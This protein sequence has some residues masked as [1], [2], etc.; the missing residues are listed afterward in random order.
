MAKLRDY[1]MNGTIILGVD[2]VTGI[3]RRRDAVLRLLW[4]GAA[5]QSFYEGLSPRNLACVPQ[6]DTMHPGM[7]LGENFNDRIWKVESGLITAELY[8]TAAM[9]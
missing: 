4:A 1:N 3:I 9:A 6:F 8:L 7:S 5:S 2:E